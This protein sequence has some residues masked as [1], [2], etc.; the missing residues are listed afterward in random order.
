MWRLIML[1]GPI[2]GHACWVPYNGDLQITP[3]VTSVDIIVENDRMIVD[4]LPDITYKFRSEK[5]EFVIDDEI[6]YFNFISEKDGSLRMSLSPSFHNV[7]DW[8]GSDMNVYVYSSCT[9]VGNTETFLS[10]ST[11]SNHQSEQRLVSLS[12]DDIIIFSPES[13]AW[14]DPPIKLGRDKENTQ[15]VVERILNGLPNTLAFFVQSIPIGYNNANTSHIPPK[16]FFSGISS[17]I[18]SYLEPKLKSLGFHFSQNGFEEGCTHLVM[19]KLGIGNKV[20]TALL[21]CCDIVNLEWCYDIIIKMGNLGCKHLDVINDSSQIKRLEDLSCCTLLCEYLSN[22]KKKVCRD[23]TIPFISLPCLPFLP[24]HPKPESFSDRKQFLDRLRVYNEL[25]ETISL[26]NFEPDIK[27]SFIFKNSKFIVLDTYNDVISTKVLSILNSGGC[28]N[29]NCFV[30]STNFGKNDNAESSFL[31]ELF[32]FLKKITGN[33][34]SKFLVV[35]PS[36]IKLPSFSQMLADIL[37][38]NEILVIDTNYL[39]K[40]ILFAG[41]SSI[42]LLN[43]EIDKKSHKLNRHKNLDLAQSHISITNEANSATSKRFISIGKGK[44]KTLVEDDG[45]VDLVMSTLNDLIASKA[46]MTEHISEHLPS[47]NNIESVHHDERNDLII[48]AN[49]KVDQSKKFLDIPNKRKPRNVKCFKKVKKK[50]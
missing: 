38:N 14:F 25:V 1:T 7:K 44:S 5:S 20:I 18:K 10:Y 9:D 3:Y 43:R 32:I 39:A 29:S 48:K 23:Y 40:M 28:P 4:A 21:T 8:S 49:L 30:M 42:E 41:S 24:E 12:E 45:T 36:F 15:D 22:I 6:S 35:P 33:S 19:Q 16:L 46:N 27:R 13:K 37:S 26:T 17:K 31:N 34:H 50:M 2:K 47:N 11:N